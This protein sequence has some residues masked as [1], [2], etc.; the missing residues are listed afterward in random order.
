LAKKLGKTQEEV[1]PVV[2]ALEKEWYTKIG[3]S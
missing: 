3:N 1:K 2:D